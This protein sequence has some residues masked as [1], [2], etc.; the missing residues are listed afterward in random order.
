MFHP[1]DQLFLL[2]TSSNNM[3]QAYFSR[4]GKTMCCLYCDIIIDEVDE[5]VNLARKHKLPCEYAKLVIV[6]LIFSNL[7]EKI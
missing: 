4:Y 5:T 3:A 2:M 7:K 6:P 1:F